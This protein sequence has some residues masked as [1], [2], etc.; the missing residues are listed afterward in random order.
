MPTAAKNR[1]TPAQL[2]ALLAEATAW[3][4]KNDIARAEAIYREIL[5][6][7]PKNF[8]A[9]HMLAVVGYQAK[10]IAPALEL[11]EQAINLKPRDF[12]LLVNYGAALKEAQ[13]CE[14]ALK[15]YDRALAIQPNS[16]EALYNK[17][18]AYLILSRLQEAE[19]FY[20]KALAINDADP[21][22]HYGFS[23]ALYW[24]GKKA[25][26]VAELELALAL[27]PKH[28]LSYVMLGKIFSDKEWLSSAA[29]ML[30]RAVEIDPRHAFANGE[31][32]FVL[33]RL[34]RLKEGWESYE[35]R[36]WYHEDQ[37]TL[38]R[39]VPPM[40]WSGEDLSGQSIHIWP[41]QGIGDEIMFSSIV[42][43]VVSRAAQVYLECEPRLVD[44]FRRSFP[45][46][47]IVPG[48]LLSQKRAWR[49]DVLPARPNYQISI[50]SLGRILRPDFKAF[51]RHEGYL[52]SDSSKVAEIK[53]R[54]GS[55]PLV[56]ISW[57]SSNTDKKNKSS[58]L[59]DWG[60][61]LRVGGVTFVNLQYGDVASE[62]ARVKDE[63]G[64]DIINDSNVDQL[65]DM[66]TFF[67]QVEAMDLVVTTSNTA[68]H[69][70]GA[71]GKPTWLMLPYGGSVH[72][73]WF[74]NTDVNPWYPSVRD[75][76]QSPEGGWSPVFARVAHELK[77]WTEARHKS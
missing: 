64:V 55:G 56:G 27:D 70:A 46:L 58:D 32:S 20:R 1:Y 62:V 48:G 23:K 25:E 53:A 47:T 49:S 61:I 59:A 44:I 73:Y 21:E 40:Y 52:K 6:H 5:K 75:F 16:Y 26:A 18:Q 14:D 65:S 13:R 63:A 10:Q 3:H 29:L 57:R 68:A 71:L 35:G 15:L 24:Q 7:E 30:Q 76:R 50:A 12:S 36:F 33:L 22:A 37:K 9:L 66:D 72:W 28:V 67:A 11:F 42:P 38:R 51:P 45:S 43:E 54:Y 17:A 41:E 19:D 8:D 74:W 39:P 34:G 77:A 31:C 69:V 2:R 60:P 4:H